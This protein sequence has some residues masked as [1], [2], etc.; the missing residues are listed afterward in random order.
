MLNDQCRKVALT[1]AS[2]FLGSHLMPILLEEGLEATCLKRPSSRKKNFPASVRIM[3]GDCLDKDSLT[4]LLSEQ[5]IFIHMA[6]TLFAPTWQSYLED[7]AKIAHNIAEAFGSLPEEKRPEKVVFVSSLA[8]AGPCA[9]PPGLNEEAVPS[10]V[11]AYGWSKLMAEKTL[12][13]AMRERLIIIRPPI[14]Y[15]SGDRGL[16]PM[17]KSASKGFGISPGWK[18]RFPV[19]AIHARDVSKAILLLLQKAAPGIYHI[20]DGYEY[21][22]DLFCQAMGRATGVK[23]FRTIKMPL[24]IMGVTASL[25]SLWI[26]TLQGIAKFA[27]RKSPPIPQWNLDKYREARQQGWLADATKIKKICGFI[28]TLTLEEGMAEAVEGYRKTGLL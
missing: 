6:S 22:M 5:N 18:R 10:P 8:A 24:P 7:N 19:S 21:D 25:A 17:F 28:P 13:A 26:N 23:S 3:E 9:V 16:L 1:G 12:L 20:N 14:I 27:G 2:G 4:A 15:G 11:S